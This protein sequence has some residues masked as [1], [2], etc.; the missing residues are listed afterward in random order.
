V[1]KKL[2]KGLAN[3]RNFASSK[4]WVEQLID[5]FLDG[6]VEENRSGRDFHPSAAGKCPRLI[7][8]SMMGLIQEYH[9]PRVKRIFDAGHDMHNRYKRYFERAGKLIAEEESARAKIDGVSIVGRADLIVKDFKG[10]KHLLEL[11]T[12]NSRR[13]EEILKKGIYYEDHFIQWN[14]YSGILKLYGG[15][16]LYENK[17][18]Q[19]MKIFHVEFNDEKFVRT[20]NMFKAVD[21]H[22][23]RGLLIRKPDVCDAKFCVAKNYCKEN[24]DTQKVDVNVKIGGNKQK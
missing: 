24:K 19:R 12:V 13:F 6:R 9:E 22:I 7:Q 3:I 20:I 8:L 4:N 18:D 5:D 10:N 15:E 17:D 14:L 2:K 21:Y 11:K 23:E 1:E 16:I